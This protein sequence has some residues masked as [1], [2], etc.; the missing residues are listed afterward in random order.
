MKRVEFRENFSAFFPQGQSKLSVIIRCPYLAGVRK[1]GFDC[2]SSKTFNTVL[3]ISV[4]D[5]FS[6]ID[7]F[8]FIILAK[9]N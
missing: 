9:R 1:A 5:L 7:L 6:F 4:I 2:T 8:I 3:F